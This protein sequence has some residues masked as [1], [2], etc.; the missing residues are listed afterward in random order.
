M[1]TPLGNSCLITFKEMQK[2]PPEKFCKK[3]VLKN[4]A[5]F[6]GKHLCWRPF[7]IHNIAKFFRALIL[8]NICEWLFY[9][10]K[11]KKKL[12]ILVRNFKFT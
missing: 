4:F 7:L 8:K 2:Q 5:I 6:T 11:T 3:A 12:K 10:Y 1:F 9:V